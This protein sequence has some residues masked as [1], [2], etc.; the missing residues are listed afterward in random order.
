MA[1]QYIGWRCEYCGKILSS[2]A[3][4]VRHE[5]TCLRNPNGKN[6]LTCKHSVI[7]S[8]TM[9]S[10]DDTECSKSKALNCEHYEKISEA[11]E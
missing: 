2:K 4:A 10:L 3:Y 9:C 11:G 1:Y 5:C 6:C 7:R 8:K